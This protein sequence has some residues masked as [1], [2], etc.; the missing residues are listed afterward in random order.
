MKMDQRYR[1]TVQLLLDV[2]RTAG[3]EFDVPARFDTSQM[4]ISTET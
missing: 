1:E 3:F 4:D 2:A